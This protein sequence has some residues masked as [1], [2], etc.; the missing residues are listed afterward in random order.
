[1]VTVEDPVVAVALA[2]RVRVLEPPEVTDD[3]L[4]PAV[5]PAGRPLAVRPTVC[6]VPEVVAV[7]TVVVVDEPRC[8]VPLFGLTEIEKSLPGAVVHCASPACAGTLTASHAAL[9]VRH[10]CEDAP[11]RLT[12]ARSVAVRTLT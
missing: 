9:T 5:T 6:A 11:N 7:E 8:A 10:S 1:M 2:D 3:G 4:K 12:A